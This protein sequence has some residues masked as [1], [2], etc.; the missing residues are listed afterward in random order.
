MRLKGC[1]FFLERVG[2]YFRFWGHDP[3]LPSQRENAAK[4]TCVRMDMAAHQKT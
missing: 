1:R 4:D 3:A 2:Q